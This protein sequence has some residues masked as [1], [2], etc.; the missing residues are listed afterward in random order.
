MPKNVCVQPV[1][2]RK[3]VRGR[4]NSIDQ[5]QSK[6]PRNRDL[7]LGWHDLLGEIRSSSRRLRSARG[8]AHAENEVPAPRAASPRPETAETRPRTAVEA[9][10]M[11]LGVSPSGIT[12]ETVP[13]SLLLR[14]WNYAIDQRKDEG[15]LPLERVPRL[16]VTQRDIQLPQERNPKLDEMLTAI[17]GAED[18]DLLQLDEAQLQKLKASEALDSARAELGGSPRCLGALGVEE[19]ETPSAHQ[20]RLKMEELELLKEG[21]SFHVSLDPLVIEAH[22]T[23]SLFELQARPP[24]S[25]Y[26]PGGAA[27][28]RLPQEI[29]LILSEDVDEAVE[30]FEALDPKLLGALRHGRRGAFDEGKASAKLALSIADLQARQDK[31]VVRCKKLRR[32]VEH[33]RALRSLPPDRSVNNEEGLLSARLQ[34]RVKRLRYDHCEIQSKK[35]QSILPCVI[36]HL[37]DHLDETNGD[38]SLG[39]T[40]AFLSV[41]SFLKPHRTVVEKQRREVHRIYLRQVEKIQ[42]FQRLLADPNRCP[43]RGEIY[44]SQCFRHVLLA[45]LAVDKSYFFRV[46]RHL[47][48]E[49]FQEVFTVNFLAACC[50]A[51]AIPELA[52]RDDPLH[53]ILRSTVYDAVLERYSSPRAAKVVAAPTVELRRGGTGLDAPDAAGGDAEGD[54]G[55]R[56]PRPPL[57]KLE[58]NDRFRDGHLQLPACSTQGPDGRQ[59]A[60]C[61][62]QA[63]NSA[64]DV[65]RGGA[66][67]KSGSSLCE[68]DTAGG[69]PYGGA[70]TLEIASKTSLLPSLGLK[71]AMADQKEK[72]IQEAKALQK[73]LEE[74]SAQREAVQQELQAMK[75]ELGQCQEQA[76]QLQG[77]LTTINQEMTQK[78]ALLK[79]IQA[80]MYKA[81][82]E[83]MACLEAQ[84]SL[85]HVMKQK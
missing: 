25:L 84:P 38:K 47:E 44:L 10:S 30:A 80:E 78:S 74:I 53:E 75:E 36:S 15:I 19:V 3:K 31:N 64:A 61:A 6:L 70:A 48:P 77:R 4:R 85:V 14:M 58:L 50:D 46:L 28:D 35:Q 63:P 67:G 39:N 1:A 7:L 24:L 55:S 21:G 29:R 11:E 60:L 13:N 59:P 69:Q 12:E 2:S 68:E 82:N 40:N 41:L 23:L 83:Y 34:R 65:G 20:Q 18:M 9:A 17:F 26:T 16:T 76:T 66:P 56:I 49:D 54:A 57:Q 8:G 51:F 37:N 81:E 5:S 52:S 22:Q 79:S 27:A 62:Q 32:G 45:G 72:Q 73:S 42:H 71:T 43:E 33:T